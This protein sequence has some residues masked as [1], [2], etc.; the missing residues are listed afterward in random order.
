MEDRYECMDCGWVGVE[1]E[2]HEPPPMYFAIDN[3]QSVCPRCWS[4]DF[5]VNKI[6][7]QGGCDETTTT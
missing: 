7:N 5:Y 1:T 2:T 4:L 3:D 6:K